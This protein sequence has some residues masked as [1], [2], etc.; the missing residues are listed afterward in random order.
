MLNAA[1]RKA[2]EVQRT[3]FMSVL[4]ATSVLKPREGGAALDEAALKK[5]IT[6]AAAELAAEHEP[7][8]PVDCERAPVHLQ[9]ASLAVSAQR[10]LLRAA[11]SGNY[12]PVSRH[13]VRTTVAGALGVFAPPDGSA[14]SAVP[15]M[16]M[17]NKI[18]TVMTGAVFFPARKRALLER[19]VG[20]FER[21]LV[22][23]A[24]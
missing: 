19:M 3:T 21:D 24:P 14:P 11:E 17:P 8:L 15:A 7:M 22:R 23:A 20:N 16:W 4:R 13:E 10:A 1:A 5:A 18:A 12:E 6:A 9:M 2:A